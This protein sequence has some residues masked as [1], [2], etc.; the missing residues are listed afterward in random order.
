MRLT[1]QHC[2]LIKARFAGLVFGMKCEVCGDAD[3]QVSTTLFMLNECDAAFSGSRVPLVAITCKLCGNTK[4]LNGIQM[5]IIS[6]EGELL[7]A[8]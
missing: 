1:E 7:P 4:L 5:G 6:K 2:G 3:W 8:S